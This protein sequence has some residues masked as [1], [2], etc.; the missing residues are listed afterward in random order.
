MVRRPDVLAS[1][2]RAHPRCPPSSLAGC[3]CAPKRSRDVHRHLRAIS[4]RDG[5]GAP[6]RVRPARICSKGKLEEQAAG[7]AVVIGLGARREPTSMASYTANNR[8]IEHARELIEGRQYVVRSDW[9]EVQPKAAE[10]DAYLASHTWDDYAVWHLGL[11]R[12]RATRPRAGMR[13]SSATSAA[14]IAPGSSPVTTAPPSGT[15]RRSSW[16][17][18]SS[19][20]CSTRSAPSVHV[21]R[22]Q[23]VLRTGSSSSGRS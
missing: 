3:R 23:S 19:S 17:R 2:R 15:T 21:A 16:Q 22:R 11:T 20:R 4:G 7:R 18:T 9:G 6:T 10:Q 14:C 13:S 8:A 5:C 12:A 1:G